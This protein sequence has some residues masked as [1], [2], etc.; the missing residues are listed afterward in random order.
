MA[1]AGFGVALWKSDET[2]GKED[3]PNESSDETL[4]VP[5]LGVSILERRGGVSSPFGDGGEQ[6]ANGCIVTT[7]GVDDELLWTGITRS[8]RFM[9]TP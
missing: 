6:V 3:L 2:H 7:P 9:P 4:L 5:R 8:A 1:W